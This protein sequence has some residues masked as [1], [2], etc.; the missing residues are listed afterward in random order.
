MSERFVEVSIRACDR[1]EISYD[2]IAY[3]AIKRVR[4]AET[5]EEFYI[6]MITSFGTFHSIHLYPS[7]MEAQDDLFK[8][9]PPK[10][11][12]GK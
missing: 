8:M 9:F 7:Y 10:G 11:F 2:C 5:E 6:E 12:K 1:P 3:S 4:I